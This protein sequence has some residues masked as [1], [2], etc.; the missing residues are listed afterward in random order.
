[1]KKF[2]KNYIFPPFIEVSLVGLSVILILMYIILPGLTQPNTIL[3][4]IS[5]MVLLFTGMFVV[6][7]IQS[8]LI[9][10]VN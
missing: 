4:I 3:N 7:Y 5:F 10:K 8:K 9:K 1:M 2:I 6:K